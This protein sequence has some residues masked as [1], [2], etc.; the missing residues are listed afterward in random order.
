MYF[1]DED[2]W[3]DCVNSLSVG[4]L[5]ILLETMTSECTQWTPGYGGKIKLISIVVID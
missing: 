3:N 1:A 4:V 2:I 5:L